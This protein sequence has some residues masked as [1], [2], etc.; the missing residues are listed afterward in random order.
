MIAEPFMIFSRGNYSIPAPAFYGA[1][2][3]DAPRMPGAS[4]PRSTRMAGGIEQKKPATA[5]A[6]KQCRAGQVRDI[7][8][9][10]TMRDIKICPVGWFLRF[11]NPWQFPSK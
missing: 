9:S 11:A 2:I 4:K 1:P 3:D 10:R 6:G 5:G 7:V 8:V